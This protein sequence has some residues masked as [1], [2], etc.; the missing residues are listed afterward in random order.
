LQYDH[1][2]EKN[3]TTDYT[4]FSHRDYYVALIKIK[5]FT[6]EDARIAEKVQSDKRKQIFLF[7]VILISVGRN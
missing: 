6:A 4:G 1:L 5:I 3:L 2:D 7:I